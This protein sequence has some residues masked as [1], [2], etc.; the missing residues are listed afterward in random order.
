[1]RIADFIIGIRT[2]RDVRMYF[3]EEAAKEQKL[4]LASGLLVE[5]KIAISGR[6]SQG[7]VYLALAK[8]YQKTG[9]YWA[10]T[11][12]TTNRLVLLI[13]KQK[14]AASFA[15]ALKNE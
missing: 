14:D 5:S 11:V 2:H 15:A 1:M 12:D 9:A 13:S 6:R 7:E 8:S 4:L 10:A 3:A